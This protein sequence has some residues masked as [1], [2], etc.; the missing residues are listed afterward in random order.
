MNYREDI[1]PSIPGLID[2]AVAAFDADRDT[3]RRYLLRASTLLR[4]K[5]GARTGAKR[6]GRS[7]SRGGLIAWQ[8]NRVVDYIETHLADK[9]TAMHLARLINVSVGQLFRAFKISVGVPP[10]HYIASQRVELACTM[11][12][13]T[14]ESLSQVAVACGLCD[15][16]HLCRVFRRMTG[17][18]P[19]AWRRA[20]PATNP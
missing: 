10:F 20:I 17:M 8:L 1:P 19:S 14:Q 3:S 12:R 5:R 13:T 9:I 2:A 6:S 16:A 11:M 7:E 4:V 18:S 15:Q